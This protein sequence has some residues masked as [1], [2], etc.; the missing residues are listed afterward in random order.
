[1]RRRR[2]IRITPKGGSDT[3]NKSAHALTHDICIAQTGAIRIRNQVRYAFKDALRTSLRS[4]MRANEWM[5]QPPCLYCNLLTQTRIIKVETKKSLCLS[6]VRHI[7][8]KMSILNI[9]MGPCMHS[10]SIG[11]NQ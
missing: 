9:S 11:Q 3:V 1:M 8:N 2:N 7:L 5:Y 10:A 4:S 6:L